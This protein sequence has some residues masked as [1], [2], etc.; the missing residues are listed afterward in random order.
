MKVEKIWTFLIHGGEPLHIEDKKNPPLDHDGK[1]QTIWK[2]I[3]TET[4]ATAVEAILI[5]YGATVQRTTETQNADTVEGRGLPAS[6][7]E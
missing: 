3:G 6:S 4:T 7:P 5:E 2:M 1:G